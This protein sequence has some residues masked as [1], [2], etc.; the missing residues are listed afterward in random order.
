MIAAGKD[1]LHTNDRYNLKAQLELLV[2]DD[3]VGNDTWAEL[4]DTNFKILNWPFIQSNQ[5]KT[6]VDSVLSY[7]PANLFKLDAVKMGTIAS[8]AVVLSIFF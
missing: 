4:V 2:L 7:S 8:L 5:T 3:K 6:C 1:I